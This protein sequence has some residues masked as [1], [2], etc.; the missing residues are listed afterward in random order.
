MKARITAIT[1]FFGLLL[2]ICV[3]PDRLMAQASPGPLAP[4]PQSQAPQSR[5][6][7]KP[8]PPQVPART[9]LEGPWKL[10]PDESD[11][12]RTKIQDSRGTYGGNGGGYPGGGYPGGGY[13]GGGR[14]P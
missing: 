14:Y 3:L 5:P 7:A 11:D 9:S 13:P 4:P 12:P 2:A 6:A 10:N 1:I 8:K